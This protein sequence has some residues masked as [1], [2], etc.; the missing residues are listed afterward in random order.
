MAVR[1][2]L[3]VV[4][5][6]VGRVVYS[7]RRPR[8]LSRIYKVMKC[9]WRNYPGNIGVNCHSFHAFEAELISLQDPLF[10]GHTIRICLL[11]NVCLLYMI[12]VT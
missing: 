9:H 5:T 8:M 3:R 4:F 6:A 2:K 7:D 10:E 1:S 12:E 11:A